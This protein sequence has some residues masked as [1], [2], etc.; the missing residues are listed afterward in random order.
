MKVS[1]DM[2]VKEILTEYVFG[3]GENTH[4]IPAPVE[5]ADSKLDGYPEW[6]TILDVQKSMKEQI[7]PEQKFSL[8]S[9]VIQ[10]EVFA[11]LEAWGDATQILDIKV[12]PITVVQ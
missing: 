1:L 2:K 5:F 9:P 11:L 3:N 10:E 12:T 6:D 4:V 8:L 7:L